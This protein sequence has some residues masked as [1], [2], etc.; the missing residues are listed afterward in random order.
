MTIIPSI[1]LKIK[2]IKERNTNER[3]EGVEGIRNEKFKKEEEE[4]FIDL[5]YVQIRH[6]SSQ[7]NKLRLIAAIDNF[8]VGKQVCQ[9]LVAP[10]DTRALRQ[11]IL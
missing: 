6:D 1:T 2:Y 10:R 8:E 9:T 11:E 5:N 3:A 4:E 7:F